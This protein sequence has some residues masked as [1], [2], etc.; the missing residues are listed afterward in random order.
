[1]KETKFEFYG[2]SGAGKSYLIG[3][4]ARS[5]HG[6]SENVLFAQTGKFLIFSR[7]LRCSL[8]VYF[9]LKF[10]KI[11]LHENAHKNPHQKFKR[12][13]K[14]IRIFLKYSYK[15][16]SHGA[17]FGE[18]VLH[19]IC[20]PGEKVKRFCDAYQGFFPNHIAVYIKAS[21]SQAAMRRCIRD[22]T[23][24][25]FDVALM[26]NKIQESAFDMVQDYFPVGRAIEFDAENG[27][28]EELYKSIQQCVL[29]GES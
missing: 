29:K 19:C 9:I 14:V 12:L 1:M 20:C 17:L 21:P 26:D 15:T 18:S 3:K 11:F 8:F 2:L 22:S 4:I 25:L 28:I 16:E 13:L 24:N 10:Y 23:P 27:N 7:L 6:K 5:S